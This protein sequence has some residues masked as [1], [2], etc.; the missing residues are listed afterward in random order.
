MIACRWWM[1]DCGLPN[2]MALRTWILSVSI[3]FVGYSSRFARASRWIYIDNT[4][5]SARTAYL[6]VTNMFLGEVLGV[7][8]PVSSVESRKITLVA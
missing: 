7:T 8:V 6:Y 2:V 4:G 5:H 1:E 3:S